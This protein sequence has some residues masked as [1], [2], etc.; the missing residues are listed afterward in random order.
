MVEKIDGNVPDDVDPDAKGGCVDEVCEDLKKA[1]DEPE[2][3]E[4][5]ESD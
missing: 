3:A 5:G 1:M 4:G 2:T